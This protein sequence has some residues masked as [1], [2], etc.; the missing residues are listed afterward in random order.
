MVC[1]PR[2]PS[3]QHQ[4]NLAPLA[5][6]ESYERQLTGDGVSLEI[7]VPALTTAPSIHTPLCLSPQKT[8]LF[9]YHPKRLIFNE[10]PPQNGTTL[11]PLLQVEPSLCTP[12]SH[13]SNSPTWRIRIPDL[14]HRRATTPLL[15]PLSLRASHYVCHYCSEWEPLFAWVEARGGQ[16]QNVGKKNGRVFGITILGVVEV[17]VPKQL[18][19]LRRTPPA[20]IQARAP[21]RGWRDNDG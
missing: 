15:Q 10:T 3:T 16:A 18:N 2:T 13:R 11:V 12:P 4:A 6:A 17:F 5:R 14:H 7:A 8:H 20:D 19:L 21:S 1:I 9:V